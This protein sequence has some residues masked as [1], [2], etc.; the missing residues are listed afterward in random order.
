MSTLSETVNSDT[1]ILPPTLILLFIDMSPLT[2]K[3][4]LNETSPAT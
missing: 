3:F 4:E 1:E 2:N